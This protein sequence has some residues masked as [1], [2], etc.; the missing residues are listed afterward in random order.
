MDIKSPDKKYSRKDVK[1]KLKGEL[2][3]NLKALGY[4]PGSEDEKE[5]IADISNKIL[6]HLLRS[7]NIT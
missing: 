4:N 6:S 3:E 5:T 7:E 1:N 2:L